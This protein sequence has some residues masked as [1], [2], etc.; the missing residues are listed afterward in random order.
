MA[1]KLPW[2]DAFE[3]LISLQQTGK[4]VERDHSTYRIPPTWIHDMVHRGSLGP[5]WGFNED[6][7][8]TKLLRETERQEN[9]VGIESFAQPFTPEEITAAAVAATTLAAAW[10]DSAASP[11]Q[12]SEAEPTASATPN[13]DHTIRHAE[14]ELE[15]LGQPGKGSVSQAQQRIENAN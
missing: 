12:N 7:Q 13:V 11:S 10:S 9:A 4:M 1:K 15:E 3:D 2:A 5:T 8:L 14:K 6:G